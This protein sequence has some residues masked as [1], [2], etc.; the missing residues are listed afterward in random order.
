MFRCLLL[1]LLLALSLKASNPAILTFD[2]LSY[3]SALD[4]ASH[5]GMKV[6]Y[7]NHGAPGSRPGVILFN[8]EHRIILASESRETLVDGLRV[9]LGDPVLS[10]TGRL[11]VSLN[12]YTRRLTAIVAPQLCVNPPNLPHVIVIDPGHGGTDTGMGNPRLGLREKILVLDVAKRLKSILETAGYKVVLT[13]DVDQFVDLKMRAEIA[14]MAGADL[15]ISIHFNAGPPGDSRIHGTEIITFPLAGQRSD[16]SWNDRLNDRE[17]YASPVNRFDVWS[18]VL[19]ECVHREVLNGLHTDDRGLKSKHLGALRGLNC[20]AVL[21]ES[22][23]LSS[24]SEGGRVAQPAFRQ[25][26]AQSLASGVA[27]YVRCI[28]RLKPSFRSSSITKPEV[29]RLTPTRP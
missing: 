3:V 28:E 25:L 26:I 22:A 27:S 29:Q 14:N 6:S 17:S 16:Q 19:A 15:F 11:Y 9:F 2:G 8:Q 23:F 10:R 12:D 20:P 18:A 1:F 21:V 7:T 13:R 24:D 5:L 4:V